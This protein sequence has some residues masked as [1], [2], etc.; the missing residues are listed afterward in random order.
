MAKGSSFSKSASLSVDA[1]RLW[2]LSQCKNSVTSPN[3]HYKF[4]GRRAIWLTTKEGRS[5]AADSLHVSLS[6]SLSLSVSV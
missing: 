2:H 1:A 3:L 6:L 4:K 5:L